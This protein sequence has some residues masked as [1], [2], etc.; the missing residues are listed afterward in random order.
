MTDRTGGRTTGAGGRGSGIAVR[1][2]LPTSET[3]ARITGAGGRTIVVVG[4]V[5]TGAGTGGRV[6]TGVGRGTTGVGTGRSG[7]RAITVTGVRTTSVTGI[8]VAPTIGTGGRSPPVFRG[9]GA[10]GVGG[11]GV[12]AGLSTR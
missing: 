11:L 9:G 1:P 7:G 12:A 5:T 8:G 6:I 3:G 10:F 2:R 4:L